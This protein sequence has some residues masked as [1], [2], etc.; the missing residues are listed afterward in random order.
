MFKNQI[1]KQIVNDTLK[2]EGRWSR[3]SL[4]M[5]S[6]W[7]VTVAIGLYQSFWKGFNFEVFLTFAAIAVSTK[8][9]DALSQRILNK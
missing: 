8:I 9:A 5:F 4:T 2:K 3:T 1:L 6:S 7:I